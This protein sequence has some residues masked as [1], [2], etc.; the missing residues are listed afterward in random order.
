MADRGSH[1]QVSHHAERIHRKMIYK[2]RSCLLT[3]SSRANLLIQTLI[4]YRQKLIVEPE[5]VVTVSTRLTNT[6]SIQGSRYV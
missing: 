3:D 6:M 1:Y 4:I 5:R 2:Y